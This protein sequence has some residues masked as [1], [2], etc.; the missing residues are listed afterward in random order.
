MLIIASTAGD[1]GK[2]DTIPVVL[3][4]ELAI[5]AL[6]YLLGGNVV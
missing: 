4:S 2:S 1:I 3:K 6:N 5:Q